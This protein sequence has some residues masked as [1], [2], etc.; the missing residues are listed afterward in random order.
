MSVFR[1]RSKFNMTDNPSNQEVPVLLVDEETMERLIV[2]VADY[3]QNAQASQNAN[4]G[5]ETTP[6]SS[7]STSSGSEAVTSGNT[8]GLDFFVLY[9]QKGYPRQRPKA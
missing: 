6:V 1:P 5:H 4:Q 8:G 7:S 3:I 2:G 9:N